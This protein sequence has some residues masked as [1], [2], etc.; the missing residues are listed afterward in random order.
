MRNAANVTLITALIGRQPMWSADLFT[1]SLIDASVFRWTSADQD[2]THDANTWS[3]RGPTID[4]SAWSSKNTTEIPEMS[5]QIYS[6]GTDFTEG[7]NLKNAVINGLFDGAYLTLERVFMPTFGNTS[8]GTILLFGGRI[9]AVTVDS[10]GIKLTCTASNVIMS[11]NLPR[12][13]FQAS[14]TYTLYDSGCT[15]NKADFTDNYVVSSAN[16]VTLN[17]VGSAAVDASFYLHG[18]AEITSGAGIGQKLTVQR[19]SSGGVG[20]SYPLI[21]VPA[22][23][24]TFKVSQGCSKTVARCQQFDNIVNFGGFPYIPPAMTGI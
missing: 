8:L 10:L 1:L 16:A 12:R 18:T 19:Y 4:R 3:A 2:I 23:G 7:V 24:D 13:T 5:V 17:W 9:G 11:Q 15:L 22:P 6:S 14:C 20:F 21:V